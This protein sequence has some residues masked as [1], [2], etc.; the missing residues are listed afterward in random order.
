MYKVST[1]MWM[2][3]LLVLQVLL[4][5]LMLV[6]LFLAKIENIQVVEEKIRTDSSNSMVIK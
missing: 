2:K 1:L 3:S 5:L 6:D 4:P